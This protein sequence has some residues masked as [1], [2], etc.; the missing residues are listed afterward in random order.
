MCKMYQLHNTPVFPPASEK[1]NDRLIGMGL[2]KFYFGTKCQ[3]I[4]GSAYS[5]L[6]TT[7]T[8]EIRPQNTL[9]VMY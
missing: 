8:S 3:T 2:R 5:T 6:K 1:H 4:S 9:Q 7:K